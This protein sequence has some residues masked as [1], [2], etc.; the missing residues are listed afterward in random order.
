M[1]RGTVIFRGALN[2]EVPYKFIPFAGEL[3]AGDL[4][5]GIRIY[6]I[7]VMGRQ[8]TQILETPTYTI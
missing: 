8:K 3:P 4:Q 2:K 1:R 5:V 6:R 7:A